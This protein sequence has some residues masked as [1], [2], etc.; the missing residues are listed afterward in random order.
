MKHFIQ[1]PHTEQRLVDGSIVVLQRFPNTKWIVHNSW[2]TYL[3]QQYNGWYF[4]SIPSQTIV[5]M[6]ARDLHGLTIVSNFVPG[7]SPN[8]PRPAKPPLPPGPVWPQPGK[9]PGPSN[10]P[11]HGL[12]GPPYHDGHHDGH[13]EDYHDHPHLGHAG[14]SM[15]MPPKPPT[16]PGPHPERGPVRSPERYLGGVNFF[17]GQLVYMTYGDIYQATVDFRSSWKAPSL[18]GNFKKDIQSGY[19]VPIPRG[20]FNDIHDALK[21]MDQEIDDIRKNL[22]GLGE[23]LEYSKIKKYLINFKYAFGTD[24]PTK[25]DA[26]KYLSELVPPVQPALGV[27]FKNL[28]KE[29]LTY[30][31]VFTYYPRPN[32]SG[33]L[34]FMDDTVDTIT[35]GPVVEDI[36]VEQLTDADGNNQGFRL[37]KIIRILETGETAV[38]E[39]DYPV[40]TLA[41]IQKVIDGLTDLDDK[42]VDKSIAGEGGFILMD[43]KLTAHLPEKTNLSGTKA[44]LALTSTYLSLETGEKV[45]TKVQILPAD[46][47]VY[48]IPEVDARF[49]QKV[50]K[51]VAGKG[52]RIV[53]ES[54]VTS[55]GDGFKVASRLLSLE[56]GSLVDLLETISL[57]DMGAASQ[58]DMDKITVRVGEIEYVLD[59]L[60]TKRIQIINI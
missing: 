12:P 46:F 13:H 43:A 17:Q 60:A 14:P 54:K 16:T 35:E 7:P 29:S 49:A 38:Y 1:I 37:T 50:D 4:C 39:D 45:T 52:E 25:E 36:R 21:T 57:K 53:K 56:D 9:H 24:T 44:H 42:K 6:N 30:R 58:G 10:V 22:E 8:A 5:P 51:L 34:V 47:N 27:F 28:D 32:S 18:T 15:S 41:D 23:E 19:L 40:A 31:H 55:T 26:D 48:T 2:Y 59:D 11:H 33:N 20:M 3:G